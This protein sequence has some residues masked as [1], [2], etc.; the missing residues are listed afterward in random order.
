M[1][2]ETVTTEKIDDPDKV[3]Q[4]IEALDNAGAVNIG[5]NKGTPVSAEAS[6][7]LLQKLE[8][9]DM[10]DDIV[11][12]TIAG[13]WHSAKVV[14]PVDA[15]FTFRDKEFYKPMTDDIVTRLRENCDTTDCVNVR[16]I[17]L[18][19]CDNCEAADE[20]EWL[21]KIIEG[22]LAGCSHGADGDL[23]F[24]DRCVFHDAIYEYRA[25]YPA[26]QNEY[27]KM[28]SDKLKAVRDD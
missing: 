22:L 20:I 3:A 25:K 26:P 19:K 18:V 2:G 6:Q 4:I 28:W 14:V 10:N 23:R 24:S 12:K 8:N 15:P 17:A 7:Y 1:D 21:H 16:S 5:T 9:K 13:N 11:T 27:Q